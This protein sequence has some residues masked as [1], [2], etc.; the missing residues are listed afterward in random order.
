M[1]KKEMSGLLNDG[2]MGDIL[3]ALFSGVPYAFSK[4]PADYDMLR[5]Q[6]SKALSVDAEAIYLVG[7]GRFGFSMAP[8]KYGRPFTERSDL[9]LVIVNEV[10]FDTA[11]V[12][13]IRYDFKS[14]GFDHD[15]VASLKE[16]RS[17]NVF[18][19]YLEPY[20]LK[21]SLSFYTSRWFPAFAALG[22]FPVAAGRSV[23]A[24]VYRTMEHA[25]SYHNYGLRLLVAGAVA[26]TRASGE[27]R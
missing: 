23:K 6:L 9:D 17:N 24:R 15:V 13:L 11:W 14:L 18:W 19:G 20:N 21:S 22:F 7:S 25:R 3:E 27:K 26:S 8:H 4:K 5:S 12:E 1:N 2:K 10:L 16:H